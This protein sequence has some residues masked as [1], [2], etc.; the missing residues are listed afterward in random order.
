MEN[1]PKTLFVF[2]DGLGLGV[3][4]PDV[5]PLYRGYCPTLQ[6]LLDEEAIPVD[7]CLGV[8]GRPQ[9]ASGQATIYTGRNVP[10]EIGRHEEGFPGP[11]IRG[12]VE[13][14]NLFTQF[15]DRGLKS[16]F[17][18]GY[19]LEAYPPEKRKRRAS[20]T[21]VM[22]LNAFGKTRDTSD[23]LANRALC[24]DLTKTWITDLGF[25]GGKITPT[26]SAEHLMAI[27][28]DHD[29]TLFEFFRSDLLAHK[30]TDDEIHS[31]LCELEEFIAKVLSF[32]ETEGHL[33]VFLSDHG[34]VEDTTSRSHS[35]NPV[36]LI[37][38]GQGAEH[39]RREVKSLA[40]FLS[41]LLGLY[42]SRKKE[43]V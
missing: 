16:T 18:N 37:A 23:L 32:A 15:N 4:S 31:M 28:R 41:A 35:L 3:K 9:S 39:L 1:S 6:R 7:A 38:R 43:T 20:V 29:L 24:H 33:L 42:N 11:T 25:E 8:P 10:Q 22:T 13:E 14:A 27:A 40:D 26:G 19:Y 5:N 2:I 34:N 17:A 21:T 36:P 30:G 12:I